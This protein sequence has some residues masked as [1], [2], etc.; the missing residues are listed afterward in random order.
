MTEQNIKESTCKGV[1]KE[2]AAS[3]QFRR[4]TKDGPTVSK[5]QRQEERKRAENMSFAGLKRSQE[6]QKN[7][8][9]IFQRLG[10]LFKNKP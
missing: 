3:R 6:E 10:G 8:T 7:R 9:G 1:T 2:D 5:D 4:V